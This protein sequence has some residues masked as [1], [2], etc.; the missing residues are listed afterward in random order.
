MVLRSHACCITVVATARGMQTGQL[1]PK[2][3][4]SSQRA[5]RHACA[6]AV[7]VDAQGAGP[8]QLECF[9]WP[10]HEYPRRVVREVALGDGARVELNVVLARVVG[11]SERQT[12]A[13]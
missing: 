1:I 6:V 2:G 12:C 13:A 8:V 11:Q 4:D 10:R 3:R 9:Y 5:Y 7:R